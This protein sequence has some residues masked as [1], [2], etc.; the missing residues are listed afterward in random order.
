M[1]KKP[2]EISENVGISTA[3]IVQVNGEFSSFLV[4]IKGK[5]LPKGAGGLDIT[6]GPKCQ[7]LVGLLLSLNE[8]DIAFPLSS[9]TI[10]I[11]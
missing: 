2:R 10:Y 4:I 5:P 8:C 6:G 1:E 7:D 11:R 9:C 3:E